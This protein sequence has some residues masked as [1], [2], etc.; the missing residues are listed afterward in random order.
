MRACISRIDSPFGEARARRRDLHDLPLVGLG[1]VGDLAAGPVAV[2]G[3]DHT[4]QRLHVEPVMRGDALR[5]LRRAFDRAR[6]HRG[7]RQLRRGVRA[8][9]SACPTPFS[10]RSMPGMRPDSSGPVCAVT[11]WRT[12]TSRVGGFGFRRRC[13]GGSP[14]TIAFGVAVGVGRLLRHGSSRSV[15]CVPAGPGRSAGSGRTVP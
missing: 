15:R 12:S 1:E 11:A 4:R 8:A 7:D 9:A 3:F 5:G 6:V 14:S 13:L 10:E 2:V